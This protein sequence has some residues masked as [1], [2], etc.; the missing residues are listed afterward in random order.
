MNKEV[1][2]GQLVAGLP[3]VG[4]RLKYKRYLPW[5]RGGKEKYKRVRGEIKG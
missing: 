4:G 5:L 3:T 1:K 2:G